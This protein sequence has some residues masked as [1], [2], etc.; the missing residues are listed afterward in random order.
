MIRYVSP[1]SVR[2]RWVVP[3]LRVWNS[4]CTAQALNCLWLCN[5]VICVLISWCSPPSL[6]L[7]QW[8]TDMVLVLRMVALNKYLLNKWRCNISL[9]SEWMRKESGKVRQ[10]KPTGR[11]INELDKFRCA[12]QLDHLMSLPTLNDWHLEGKLVNP[13]GSICEEWSSTPSHSSTGAD[14]QL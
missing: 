2:W 8:K 3:L 4:P 6:N 14:N 5:G 9:V 11:S 1:G 7:S 13:T 12:I 10:K